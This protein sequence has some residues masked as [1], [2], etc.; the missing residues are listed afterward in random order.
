MG[1]TSKKKQS[2]VPS[3][4]RDEIA[5]RLEAQNRK[6]IGELFDR[7]NR[8]AR[9]GMIPPAERKCIASIQSLHDRRY[10][11]E[12]ISEARAFIIR[13]ERHWEARRPTVPRGPQPKP[14]RPRSRESSTP[15]TR[16]TDTRRAVP[17]QAVAPPA[18]EPRPLAPP[19]PDIPLPEPIPGAT[20]VSVVAEPDDRLLLRLLGG[21][22]DELVTV[23]L[24]RRGIE[25]L[26]E[27][28]FD[29]LLSLPSLRG[30]DHYTYQHETVLRVLKRFRGRVLLADEVGLGKTIEGCMVLKEYMLRGQVRR[31]LILV[32]P[33]LVGQWSAELA[34]KFGIETSTTHDSLCRSDPT[35]FW[36]TGHVIVASLATARSPAQREHVLGQRFDLV[37]VDEAHHI[38]NRATRSWELVNELR[39]RFFLMLTATPV[40]TNL[41]ELY[42]LV[43]LLRP[44]TLG[45]EA[46][47][48]RRFV[49]SDDPAQPR[50]PEK[51]RELLREVMIR[52]T[53]AVCGVMLPPRTARTIIVRPSAEESS[54]YDLLLQETRRLGLRHRP[55]FRL[56]LE[57]AGSSPQALTSTASAS[58]AR[59]QDPAVDRALNEIADAA[60]CV[61]TT[62]K[63][64]RLAELIPGDKVLVFTRFRA[65]MDQIAAD[66][67]GRGIT[68]TPFHGGMTA[69]EKDSAVAAFAADGVDVLLC[70]EIGGE[71]RNLQ[72]CHRLINFDLPWNPM[73]IEQRIG[74]IHRIG[75]TETVEVVNLACA[76]T[77]EE[78]ILDVLDRRVNLFEL[79]V[80]EMDLL[81]GELTDERDFE[82]QVF[83]IYAGSTADEQVESGFE[84]LAQRL[85]GA[86]SKLEKTRALD[87]A[88]FGQGYE[89]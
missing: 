62:E 26:A 43:T 70:S 27:E 76:E 19:G 34:D 63:L 35:R 18:P 42:N 5:R 36:S 61:R 46:D 55:L 20:P 32:P 79:V 83:D 71:G 39:S 58:R 4:S 86:R 11:K 80:G 44:G 41:S 7:I 38:K 65:T 51:L 22:H 48:R 16:T 21:R 64:D 25:L 85:I 54:L 78:R 40:E 37:L 12:C 74:R 6:E 2:V 15:P 57:E 50:D 68:F 66:L 14:G 30:V 56:L 52:N 33:A 3:L 1:R 60:R 8:L 81:L 13:C 10:L 87:E 49:S 45:T 47:F 31:A 77:A 23:F 82:D 88:L 17:A 59:G 75:Q 89:A 72:F 9:Q 24:A 73:K 29:R 84:E 28:R 53:R 67:A 69:Q